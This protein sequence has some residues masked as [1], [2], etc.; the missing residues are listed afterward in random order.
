M[1]FSERMK[2]LPT[3]YKRRRAAKKR[4]LAAMTRKRR[5]WRRVGIF[6][7]WI[8]A[9]VAV[10][11]VITVVLFYTLTN[12]PRPED[13]SLPQVATI[14]YS[15]GSVLA[16]FGAQDRTIVSL[17]QVPV[18]VRWEVLAAEDRG[19]YSE[20]G[21][22]IRGTVRAALSDLTGGD[23]QGG[24]GITQQYVKNAYLNDSRSLSRKLKEL[25][26]AMK[27]SR[28][29]SKDQILEYYLNTVYFGRGAY[30][31]QAAAQAYF[32]VDI[33]KVNAAQGAVLAALLRAPSYYDPAENPD[34][35][36]ARWQY[37]IAG[38]VSTKHL[39]QAQASALKY[40]RVLKPR[41]EQLG[42]TGWAYL[43]EQ[44]VIAELAA[45]GITQDDITNRGLVIKT[46]LDHNAQTAAVSAIQQTFTG[47]T[48]R[49]AQHEEC[50]RR[51]EPEDRRRAR[52]LRRPERQGLQRQARLQ[53]LRGGGL[54][55]T[56]IVVQALH[57]GHRAHRDAGQD[58]GRSALH[59]G[60]PGRRQLLRDSSRVARSATTRATKVS[61]APRSR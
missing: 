5:I 36:K 6:G 13:L 14:E 39:T 48:P 35:A 56:G 16:R 31:I 54:A 60:Q 40:P 38:M 12:V 44:K 22:S 46:T 30:G 25:M 21:V 49:A 34:A 15:D 17:E 10:I 4:R 9:I 57:P 24:S 52:L 33:S 28:E 3:W 41:D 32:G 55:A 7:T 8:L 18:Q 11:M 23:T 50:A 27:L 20:P 47:L 43:I 2:H 1:S 58:A 29:Y 53:R 45:N 61:A 26:I 59:P 19:F 37:V 51:G 42:A